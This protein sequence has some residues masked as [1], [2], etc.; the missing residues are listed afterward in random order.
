MK[1]FLIVIAMGTITLNMAAC[2]GAKEKDKEQEF[3]WTVDRF[4]D[5]R[6]MQYRVPGF[7]ALPLEQKLLVYYLS[8]AALWGRDILFDQNFKY[9]LPVRRTLEGIYNTWAGDRKSEEW[10]AFETYLKKVWFANGV[11]HHYSGDKFKPG[12]SEEY[13]D[14]LLVGTPNDVLPLDFGTREELIA[15]VKPVIFDPSLWPLRI[16]QAEGQDL[17]QTSAMNYYEGV[18][19]A[20]AEKFYADMVDPKDPQPISYGLNSKLIK[21]DGK[22]QEVVW[23]EGGMYG[24]AIEQITH[25]LGKAQEVAEGD[26]KII[27]A[28]LIRYYKTGDLRDFDTY[29]VA[30]VRDTV[31]N[32]DFVNGFIENYGDPLGIKSSWESNANFKNEEATKRTEVISANAQWFEDHSPVAP[33]YKKAKVKGVSA[34]VINVAMLGGDCYPATPIGINLPNADWIRRDYGSKS[35]TIQNI[36]DAYDKAAEGN[37]FKE[38]FVLRAED[39]ARM[40]K[41]GSLGDNLH[42]DLHECLGHGS[43]QLAPGVTG[44]ELK[45]YSSPLE[46][47]RADLFALYYLA[48]PKMI[49][50]GLVPSQDVAWAEYA[51]Y[52]MN[53]M[54]T[55]LARI[56]P[57]K[58]VEQAHM[59]NR[60]AISEWCYAHGRAD[61]VIEKVV[62][63][64]KTYIVVNDFVKLRSLVGELL[65][66]VQRI[67]SEGDFAAC[68][69]FIET[70]GVQVD[71]ALHAEVLQRYNALNLA[72]YGGFINPR[73]E[74]VKDMNTG[75]VED[76]KVI[77]DE[78]Y[79]EQMV[80]Y[81]RNYSPLPSCN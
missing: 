81:S 78:G 59:R 52:I 33:Q 73:Y 65:A 60:K 43:G 58:N 36:T 48:D 62:R 77:Y 39:R 47:S 61:N 74:L 8:E 21:K 25:W 80:R 79:A 66:E 13:F 64:G 18:T 4:D 12:F 28:D 57:G 15:T 2:G 11:H 10:K 75:E 70:Y 71:P 68:R 19:Q 7:D 24:K 49:E 51:G 34:K 1:K 63:E 44:T 76:V 38:E 5:I 37:G 54:M 17:L 14:A 6:V 72:P 35:V 27:I 40:K 16:N 23:K 53:G 55:Q 29:N 26:Q 32:V 41:Y 9:N 42:T 67:K 50:L 30:W 22:I 56:E 45:Q 31:S 3:Q 69:D 20:E 46:E